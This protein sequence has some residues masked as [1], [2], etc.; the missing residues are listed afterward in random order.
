MVDLIYRDRNP[1]Q[2]SEDHIRCSVALDFS[3]QAFTNLYCA[4]YRFLLMIGISEE[5]LLTFMKDPYSIE[6]E[7]HEGAAS[8]EE[9]VEPA[10]ASAVE[11]LATKENMEKFKEQLN[12]NEEFLK[13]VFS[14]FVRNLEKK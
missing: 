8:A 1:N 13:K 7:E 12:S 14:D 3:D 5:T 9:S 4:V 10:Q 11:E 2:N 6:D